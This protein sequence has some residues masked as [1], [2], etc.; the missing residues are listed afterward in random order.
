MRIGITREA[1]QLIDLKRRGEQQGVDVIALLA[2][3]ITP[4]P[5]SWLADLEYL[6]L[7]PVIC[8]NY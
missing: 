8:R 4:I 5:I 3:F 6:S 2:T 7:L 1:R